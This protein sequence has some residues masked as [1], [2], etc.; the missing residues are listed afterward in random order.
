MHALLLLHAEQG[1]MTWHACWKIETLRLS[2]DAFSI[3]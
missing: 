3:A 2:K 1:V